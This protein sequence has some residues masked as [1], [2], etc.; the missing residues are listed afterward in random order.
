MLLLNVF[1][2]QIIL[3]LGEEKLDVKFS[4]IQP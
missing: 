1:D 4:L 3:N 2:S